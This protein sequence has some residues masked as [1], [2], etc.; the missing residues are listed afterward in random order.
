M[1]DVIG[2]QLLNYVS[3]ISR[4]EIHNYIEVDY[5]INSK[6]FNTLN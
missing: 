6:D 3:Q 4:T 5:A 2:H 1:E